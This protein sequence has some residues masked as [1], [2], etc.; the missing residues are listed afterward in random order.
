VIRLPAQLLSKYSVAGSRYTSY[1]SVAH[2]DTTPS[3]TQWLEH[4]STAIR[5][6]AGSAG[7]AVYVHIP[8]CQSLCTF[9]GCNVRIARNHALAEPY[10]DTVLQEHRLYLDRLGRSQLRLGE[11]YLGGGTPTFLPAQTL[12]RLLSGLLEK[13]EIAP[14]AALTAEID[15]RVTTRAHL[16]VL[17]RH[18]FTRLSIGVQDFDARVLD[19]VNRTQTEV[20]VRSAVESARELGFESIGFDLLYGLPLQ[21]ADSI[22]TTMDAVERLQPDRIAFY[23]YVPVPWIKPSQRQFTDADLPDA[24]DR[25][26]LYELGRERLGSAGY[27]EIG[28][29][30]YALA[31][32]ALAQAA[33]RGTLHRNFMGYTPITTRLLLGLGVSAMSDAGTAYA[34]NDKN[35]MRYELRVKNGELPIQRGHLLTEEDRLS[36]QHIFELVTR[37][38]TAATHGLPIQLDELARD[39]LVSVS[40]DRI[41]VTAL[42]R[43]FLRNICASFDA[44]LHQS[45]ASVRHHASGAL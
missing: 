17:R 13:F 38:E 33:R 19:I 18:G 10:V 28:L 23:G 7:I 31:H 16:E 43:S 3:A 39:G 34:Q 1:P 15:P 32:D 35:P 2:W 4:A 21:T 27:E 41:K 8:F 22:R 14:T 6:D 5:G 37:F 45:T 40:A 42:G 30:Q 12:Q 25:W 26:H 29:D 9:C 11:L 20:Q 44:R 24:Q 36:R